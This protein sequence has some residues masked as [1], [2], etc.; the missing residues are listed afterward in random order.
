MP[1]V[2]WAR[3]GPAKRGLRARCGNAQ[4]SVEFIIRHEHSLSD[5]ISP[6]KDEVALNWVRAV[7]VAC[8]ER[9]CRGVAVS[10]AAG[11]GLWAVDQPRRPGAPPGRFLHLI[12]EDCPLDLLRGRGETPVMR[13]MRT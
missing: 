7:L 12:P 3:A 8:Y 9:Y 2:P 4:D 13:G 6:L 11:H 10:K 5:Q 1:F